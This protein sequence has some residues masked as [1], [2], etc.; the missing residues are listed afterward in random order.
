MALDLLKPVTDSMV[1]DSQIFL[2]GILVSVGDA[3]PMLL[4]WAYQ[5]GSIY[6]RLVGQYDSDALMPL[7][8]MKEKLGI[9]SR[10]W[11]AGGKSFSSFTKSK[12]LFDG[13]LTVVD[14]Y[15][16]ML[17]AKEARRMKVLAA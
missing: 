2:N 4:F 10:R 7:I 12:N 11:K 17:Q 6:N 13:I 9:M 3:S 8:E 16:Q 14:V 15:L 1:S 5:A